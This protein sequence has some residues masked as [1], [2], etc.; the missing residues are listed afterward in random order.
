MGL[1]EWLQ[2]KDRE[3]QRTIEYLADTQEEREREVAGSVHAML[4]ERRR[5]RKWDRDN[6]ADR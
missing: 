2:R 5:R 6:S 1:M 4:W 3:N